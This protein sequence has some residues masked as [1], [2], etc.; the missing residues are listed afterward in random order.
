MRATRKKNQGGNAIIEF[1]ICSFFLWL[2]FS[3]VYGVG[4]GLYVYNSLMT[5]VSNAAVFGAARNYDTASPDSYT[6]AVKNM[7]VYGDA[8]A[9]TYPLVPNLT[10]DN[11]NIA[12]NPTTGTP[13]DLTVS[14]TGYTIDSIFMSF[15]LSG[16]PKA[17]VLYT[18]H[19]VCAS[20]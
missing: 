18:G 3:G 14:I 7:V 5:S 15:S 9:G 20:C 2:S 19:I 17:T 1:A 8:T 6:T 11:V 10:T 16:K 13:Q 12:L 4:Y